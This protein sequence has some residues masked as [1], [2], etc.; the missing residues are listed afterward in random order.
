M[1]KRTYKKNRLKSETENTNRFVR[2]QKLSVGLQTHSSRVE[3]TMSG[4]IAI[5]L[6]ALRFQRGQI[7]K[8][9]IV[10]TIVERVQIVLDWNQ[11]S[12]LA[13]PVQLKKI[14]QKMS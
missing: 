1:S 5:E 7:D 9:L 8:E 12:V 13:S 3:S 4:K 11:I 6:Q 2:H 10:V 14:I